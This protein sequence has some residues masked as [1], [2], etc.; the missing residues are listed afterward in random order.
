MKQFL[1]EWETDYCDNFPERTG[2]YIVEAEN[3]QEAAKKFKLI[4]FSKAVIINIS[5]VK[6]NA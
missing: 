4:S 2:E 3:E 1:I 5:E 6:N